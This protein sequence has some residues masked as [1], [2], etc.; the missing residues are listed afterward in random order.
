MCLGIISVRSKFRGNLRASTSKP[1]YQLPQ[2]A[3]HCRLPPLA[4]AGTR[5]SG[6]NAAVRI[7]SPGP[8]P[9]WVRTVT[10]TVTGTAGIS[11]RPELESRT[12][13][14]PTRLRVGLRV[15]T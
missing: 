14:A 11:L 15:E 9:G 7:P 4:N 10:A 1:E 6:Q 5:S 2:C 3:W 13:P 8:R 12:R